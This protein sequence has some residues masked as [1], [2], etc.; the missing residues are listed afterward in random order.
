VLVK[1]LIELNFSIVGIVEAGICEA[2]RFLAEGE[3]AEKACRNGLRLKLAHISE[4]GFQNVPD[5]WS[6]K[7]DKSD[8]WELRHGVLRLFY[9]KG[10]AGQIAVCVCGTR[11]KTRKVDP[12][13]VS[14]V[15]RMRQDYFS[16]VETGTLRTEE[17]G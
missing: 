1:P 2:E 4:K 5:T 15:E 13:F 11:K 7:V 16:A 14:R 8:I 9:F 10:Y 17:M 3:V 6:R 12:R